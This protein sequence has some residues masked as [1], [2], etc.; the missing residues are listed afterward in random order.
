MEKK[1]ES[2]MEH[3]DMNDLHTEHE[4][5]PEDNEMKKAKRRMWWSWILVI[6][7]AILM[8]SERFFG[9]MFFQEEIT[10]IILLVLA[11]PILFIFG[12]DTM[13]YGLKA[14]FTFYFTMDSLIALGTF[15]AYLTGILSLF[16]AIPDYSG[17]AGMIMAFFLTGRYVETKARGRASYAI[18]RLLNLGAKK[19]RVLRG[20]NEIE[21][22]VE[23]IKVGDIMVIKPGEKIPTDGIVVRGES[24]VDESIVTG[25]SMPQEKKKGSFVIGATINQDGILYVKA[26]KIGKDTFL[27]HVIQMVEEAQGT[28]IPIQKF[29]D[30]VTAIFVPVILILTLFTFLGWLFFSGDY[31]RGLYAAIAVLVIAC[32]CALGLATPTALMVGSGVGA[33][34]GILIRKG[35]AIQTLKDVKTIVFDKTGTLTKGKPVVTEVISYVSEHKLLSIAASLESLSEHPL[36]KAVVDEAKKRKLGLLKVVKFKIDRGKGVLGYI[37]GKKVVIGNKRLMA[38][39]KINIIS[40]QKDLEN[41]EMKGE[42]PLLVSVDKKIMGILAVADQLKENARATVSRLKQMGFRVIMIT[43]DNEATARAIAKQLDCAYLAEVLPEDKLNKIKEIQKKGMVVMVGDGV[44]D[45]PALKQ[46]NVGIALGTGTD[47]AIE[48]GDVVL[49]RGNIEGV[50]S[51]LVL[52]KATFRKIKQNLFWAFAYNVVAIPLAVAGVLHPV[53]A[54]IAMALSSITV[55]TNANLLKRIKRRM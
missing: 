30:Q 28:K 4:K 47:I 49:V 54:E 44:N 39:N 9:M 37:Q 53:V 10:T 42:T 55:V 43:G 46:A 7:I 27:A 29:A 16:I 11:F 14:Y 32:P 45:A 19:A 36:A 20:K 34:K 13:K 3:D 1:I 8:L 41:I 2:H 40:V 35:E 17:I 26:S 21:I 31:I 25:E 50:V 12:W 24:A 22:A 38:E 18:K 52:S 6:P 5:S 23:E 48:A 15:I 51:S 33:E